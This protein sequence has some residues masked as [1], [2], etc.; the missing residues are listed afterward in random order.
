MPRKLTNETFKR[1]CRFAISLGGL[2][3]PFFKQKITACLLAS[4]GLS[5]LFRVNDVSNT[6]ILLKPRER[7]VEKGI[8]LEPWRTLCRLLKGV[9]GFVELPCLV[10]HFS[11]QKRDAIVQRRW[12]V[13]RLGVVQ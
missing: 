3:Q 10:L 1:L 5:R 4:V 8:G 2:R 13:E 12:R 11:A 9:S 7:G 6:I